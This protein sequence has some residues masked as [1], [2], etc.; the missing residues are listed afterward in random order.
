M[1]HP[2]DVVRGGSLG[3]GDSGRFGVILSVVCEAVLFVFVL[4]VSVA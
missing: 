3:I 4:F 2:C 1:C